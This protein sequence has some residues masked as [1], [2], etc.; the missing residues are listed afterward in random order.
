MSSTASSNAT[1]SDTAV[2]FSGGWDSLYCY[3][4]AR[5]SGHEPDLLFFDYGQP[6]LQSE[7]TAVE[8]MK[9]AG[10]NV[11]TI[12]FPRIANSNGIFDNRNLRFLE[13]AAKLG[14]RRIYF[15]SRNLLPMFDKYGDSNW[16]FGRQQGKRLGVEVVMPATM[17]PK[18]LI[19]TECRRRAPSLAR[20]V[21]SSEGLS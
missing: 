4:A 17:M 21:F 19:T 20:Y 5:Q 13:H 7:V 10:C 8:R 12:R 6:Y 18:I 16:W 11:Q 15:G 3:I 2:L 1:L 14:Y 9:A